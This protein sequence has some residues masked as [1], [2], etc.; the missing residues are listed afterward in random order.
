MTNPL[1]LESGV[2]R[3]VEYD[4]AW[5]ELF[6]L[7]TVRIAGAL[8]P[9]TLRLEHVGSTAVPGLAAKPVL[10]ILADY[11]GS[12]DLPAII[13]GLQRA[14]Y[15]HRGE[16]GIPGREFFRRGQPRSYHV[17]L[18]AVGGDFWREHLDFRALLRS[19][20][21]TRDAYA[22]LKRDLA[23][24]FPRNREAYIEGKTPFVREALRR[25]IKAATTRPSTA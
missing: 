7:E 2:V 18:T 3:L 9:L 24:R 13:A 11:D 4:P 1:G 12:V 16:Q 14:E 21:Q 6:R 15:L 17:H 20:P 25:G 23:S 22:A 19:D 10:D 8:A 5:P